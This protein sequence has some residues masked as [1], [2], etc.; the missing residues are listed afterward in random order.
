MHGSQ[1]C[2]SEQAAVANLWKTG[3]A[4]FVSE[5]FGRL[6]KIH[7][8][9]LTELAK[10]AQRVIKQSDLLNVRLCLSS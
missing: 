1:L 5:E 3:H 8:F 9:S 4:V 7:Y 10:R 2:V 6:L